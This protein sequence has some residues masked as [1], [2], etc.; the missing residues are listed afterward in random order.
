VSKPVLALLA[1]G[2]VLSGVV[3]AEATPDCTISGTA[4][5]D[6]LS[7]TKGNDV[8]C[9]RAGHDVV[10]GLGGDDVLRGGHGSDLIVP[11]R[12]NDR[13]VGGF[14]GTDTLSYALTPFFVIVNVRRGWVAEHTS[15]KGTQDV[16]WGVDEFVGS[17]A[18]DWM[19]GGGFSDVFFGAAGADTV[20]GRSGRD[21]LY[22]GPGYD[23][24]VGGDGSDRVV[25][26]PADD[27]LRA[28]D[29]LGEND[30]VRGGR[31]DDRCFIDHGDDVAG[32]EVLY[33]L[34]VG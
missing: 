28:V 23:H 32:C 10:V 8:I 22:G 1:C 20:K 33:R 34:P 27:V 18:R 19:L 31:G 21:R 17:P 24:L 30:V 3:T 6:D 25:G 2:V 5:S 16:F 13:T 15:V 4:T 26:G 7:G 29:G 12:G 11:G 14:A 9:G